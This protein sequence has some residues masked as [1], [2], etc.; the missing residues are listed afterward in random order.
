MS[1]A[2]SWSAGGGTREAAYTVAVIATL[3]TDIH[4]LIEFSRRLQ[5][6]G[7]DKHNGAGAQ[8][9]A[10]DDDYCLWFSAV[11]GMPWDGQTRIGLHELVPDLCHDHF[12][13]SVVRCSRDEP[14]GGHN[15]GRVC[16]SRRAADFSARILAAGHSCGR[17]QMEMALI[18]DR[19]E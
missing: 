4:F 15:Q 12:Y 1:R 17:R 18:G 2:S 8:S 9:D 14:L 16:I 3:K 11:G 7:E 5:F 19:R 13:R 6:T 10:N